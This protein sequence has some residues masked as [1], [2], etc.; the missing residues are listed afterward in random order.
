MQVYCRTGNLI[1]WWVMF[2]HTGFIFMVMVILVGMLGVKLLNPAPPP[3]IIELRNQ[4]Q[5]AEP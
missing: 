5:Q 1:E 4:E 2:T 3:I